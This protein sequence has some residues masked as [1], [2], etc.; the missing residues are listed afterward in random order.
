MTFEE[1]WKNEMGMCFESK[2]HKDDA[3]AVANRAWNKAVCVT[4][5]KELKPKTP[6]RSRCQCCGE[7]YF[8]K[9]NCRLST[10]RPAI[11]QGG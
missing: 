5:E 2:K 7:K 6:E 3:M 11:F 10:Y 8:H 1:W 9:N 4:M